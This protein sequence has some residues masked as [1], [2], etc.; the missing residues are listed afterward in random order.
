[1]FNG[2]DDDEKCFI[3]RRMIHVVAESAGSRGGGALEVKPP[4]KTPSVTAHLHSLDGHD[5]SHH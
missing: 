3:D 1:M 4:G 2:S 5:D